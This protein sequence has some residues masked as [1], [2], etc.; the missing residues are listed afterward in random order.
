MG[1][2]FEVPGLSGVASYTE[3]LQQK[4]DLENQAQSLEYQ[5]DYIEQ[6]TE[7]E[8]QD[9][10]E[11]VNQAIGEA[12]VATG[13]QGFDAASESS[14]S[15]IDAVVRR[16]EIDASYIELKGETEAW[17]LREDAAQIT[18]AAKNQS[19]LN[20]IHS[21]QQAFGNAPYRGDGWNAGGNANN[22]SRYGNNFDMGGFGDDS[23]WGTSMSSGPGDTS[24][25]DTSNWQSS[26]SVSTG[27]GT[28]I[29][30]HEGM[31]FY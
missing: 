24:W 5:A 21:G 25:Y 19:R 28:F 22:T 20:R 17:A 12:T 9:F 26:N 7:I 18:S 11:V 10:M 14:Q 1:F 29:D 27:D 13:A 15:A 23:V 4:K 16:G 2:N 30:S 6:S 31:V 8:V 3:G